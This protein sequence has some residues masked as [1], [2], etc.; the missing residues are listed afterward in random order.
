[1]AVQAG[2]G[3][4][5]ALSTAGYS[6]GI[7]CSG[8]E[9][10]RKSAPHRGHQ[11]VPPHNILCLRVSEPFSV[12]LGKFKASLMMLYVVCSVNRHSGSKHV[13]FWLDDL[14]IETAPTWS[15]PFR[16]TAQGWHWFWPA[17]PCTEGCLCRNAKQ[18][19]CL[20]SHATQCFASDSHSLG[21]GAALEHVG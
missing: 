2:S 13:G 5:S 8:L 15:V 21:V 6:I 3:F 17:S 10:S 7:D 11:E 1:M 9:V 14:G 20:C 4:S 19:G 18:C 16:K 12:F